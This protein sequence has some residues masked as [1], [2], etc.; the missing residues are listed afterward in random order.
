M[1]DWA[2]VHA[3][4]FSGA[5]DDVELCQCCLDVGEM[6]TLAQTECG[7]CGARICDGCSENGMCC[8]CR[9]QR[10]QDAMLCPTCGAPVESDALD[11]QTMPDG[12]LMWPQP[13]CRA[14]LLAGL[15]RLDAELKHQPGKGA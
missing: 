15:K 9:A 7:Q 12:S 13:F 6:T 11:K 2:R 10:G 8:E 5:N 4:R 3:D 1:S 14:C